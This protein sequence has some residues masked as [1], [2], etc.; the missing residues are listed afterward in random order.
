L[1][2]DLL[3]IVGGSENDEEFPDSPLQHLEYGIR[4]PC[5]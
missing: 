5:V 1:L 4:H 2:V 3:R